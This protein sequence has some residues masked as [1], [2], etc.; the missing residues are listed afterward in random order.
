MSDQLDRVTE[1]EF[2]IFAG[3]Q[4]TPPTAHEIQDHLQKRL[5]RFQD[6]YQVLLIRVEVSLNVH[7][8]ALKPKGGLSVSI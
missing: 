2:L 7:T 8:P 1:K 6:E 5:L 3:P 4:L